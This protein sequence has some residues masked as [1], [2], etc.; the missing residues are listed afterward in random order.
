MADNKVETQQVVYD[1]S[2]TASDADA[3]ELAAI[4]KKSVLR[5]CSKTC[6]QDSV[7]D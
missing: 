6:L 1:S 2:E 5:V 4:G 7:N 3:R